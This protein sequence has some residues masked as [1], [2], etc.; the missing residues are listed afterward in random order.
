MTIDVGWVAEKGHITKIQIR[1]EADLWT[2]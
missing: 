2:M 1:R